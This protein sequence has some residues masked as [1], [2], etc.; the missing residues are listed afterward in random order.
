MNAGC[1]ELLASLL[2]P[3]VYPEGDAGKP[4]ADEHSRPMALIVGALATHGSKDPWRVPR[5]LQERLGLDVLDANS[6]RQVG[7]GG[8]KEALESLHKSPRELARW[9]YSAA[10]IGCGQF[11]GNVA[12][13]WNGGQEIE[14]SRLFTRLLD[15][16]GIGPAKA[17]LLMDLLERDWGVTITNWEDLKVGMTDA[18]ER[19]AARVGWHDSYPSNA[20][21]LPAMYEGLRV[22][23]NEFCLKEPSCGMCPLDLVC[24]KNGVERI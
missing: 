24:S 13:A 12:W 3:V 5:A 6:L 4:F 7:R 17:V 21:K 18:M 1:A 9:I 23:A 20:R 22:L 19:M 8:I 16:T 2:M 11:G 15:F 14:A 10:I